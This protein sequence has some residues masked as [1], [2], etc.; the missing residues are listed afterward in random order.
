MAA[1]CG[2]D[3]LNPRLPPT[4]MR[5]HCRPTLD[6]LPPALIDATYS[7]P[8]PLHPVAPSAL[9]ASDAGIFATTDR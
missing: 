7:T 6:L 5:L 2:N 4:A 8:S 1:I 9:N 3:W